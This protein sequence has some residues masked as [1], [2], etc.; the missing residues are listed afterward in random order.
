MKSGSRTAQVAGRRPEVEALIEG[1]ID[2]AKPLP[3]ETER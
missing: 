1:A 2:G 3:Q